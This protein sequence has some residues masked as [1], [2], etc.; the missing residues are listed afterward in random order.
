MTGSTDQGHT[1]RRGG[2]VTALAAIIVLQALCAVFFVADVV[3]DVHRTGL[4]AHTVFEA[5]VS[6]A[7][8]VGVVFG[9]LE[10]RR[11][12]DNARRA[13]TALSA[14]S[15]AFAE[16]MAASFEHWKLT[17]AEADV[18]LLAVKGCDIAE[19]AR[20]RGAAPGTVRAQLARIYAKAGVSNRSQ[21]VSVFVED[22][23][24]G[25][26]VTGTDRDDA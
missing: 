3:G 17:P 4:Q 13:E 19:I 18:A 11:T 8:A 26:L 5:A 16:L 15:G 9:G 25:P 2:R 24:D 10:M 6:F 20:L 23:L 21:L 7:L 12:L 14:A 22:L 1:R